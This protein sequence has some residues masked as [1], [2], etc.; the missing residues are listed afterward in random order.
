M[1]V[2]ILNSHTARFIYNT[3]DIQLYGI[4]LDNLP[5]QIDAIS[6]MVAPDLND[7]IQA[8]HVVGMIEATSHISVEQGKLLLVDFLFTSDVFSEVDQF[9]IN[10][11]DTIIDKLIDNSLDPEI[12]EVVECCYRFWKLDNIHAAAKLL[13]PYKVHSKLYKDLDGY[14]LCISNKG[15]DLDLFN[16]ICSALREYGTAFVATPGN[17]AFWNEHDFLVTDDILAKLAKV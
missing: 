13:A 5:S 9:L 8:C 16:H 17:I 3:D 6:K 1:D 14:I 11:L 12:N 4:S 2:R 15:L 7:L 10:E